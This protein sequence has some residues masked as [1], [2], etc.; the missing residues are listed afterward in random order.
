MPSKD[1][2]EAYVKVQQSGRFN[3]IMDGEKAA[4]AAGL[5]IGT[6]WSVI[7]HYRELNALYG[8]GE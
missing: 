3:M 4:N 7:D 2:F 6:Y 5:D 8:K 1:E